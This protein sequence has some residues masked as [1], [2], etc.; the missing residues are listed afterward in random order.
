MP[1]DVITF[2]SA[3]QDVFMSSKD[4]KTIESD[5]FDTKKGLCMPLG[6]KMHM[7]S[8]TIVMGGVGA[9][10]AVTLARQGLN[11][12]YMGL[13]GKDSPGQGVKDELKMQ[14][15]VMDLLQEKEDLPTA[16][17]V[18]V[19]LPGAGRTILEKLGAC[20]EITEKDIPFDK[21]QAKWLYVGSLSGNS[22]N[23]LKPLVDFAKEKNIKI[24]FNPG[25][26]QLSGDIEMTK[27]LLGN[28]SILFVN[29]EEAAKLTGVDYSKE[30]DIFKKFDELVDGI[31]VMTKGKEGVIVSDGKTLFSAGIPKSGMVERTGAGDAFGSAFL[32]GYMEKEDIAHAIQLGTANSTG[33]L[34]EIGATRGLLKKG[35]W[36][37][38]EKIEVEEERL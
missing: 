28:I 31:A 4:F 35:E 21:L 38:W 33:V 24:A 5:E 22:H 17:S 8:V 25:K 7:D 37:P 10:V 30:H 36:G 18:I 14:G 26:T 32:A 27:S 23:I 2:G 9:N 15:V 13:I 19:S 12:A 29:K 11:A 6:T 34:Q 16:Y 1:Y 20:H 3:T